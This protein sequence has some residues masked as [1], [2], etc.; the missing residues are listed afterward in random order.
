MLWFTFLAY[1]SSQENYS[2]PKQ[3][4][5]EEEKLK[6]IEEKE[7]ELLR[8]AKGNVK[9]YLDYHT[10]YEK[11]IIFSSL[12]EGDVRYPCPAVINLLIRDIDVDLNMLFVTL[13]CD[14][15]ASY[16]MQ[17]SDADSLFMSDSI[18]GDKIKVLEC[19]V[20]EAITHQ[21]CWF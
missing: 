6:V 21:S 15:G 18:I 5:T 14:N 1:V 9:K 13:Q 2:F 11:K 7:G 8:K 20:V 12:L 3:P 4:A 19:S 17:F 16:M 10:E